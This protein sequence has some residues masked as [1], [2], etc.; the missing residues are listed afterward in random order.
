MKKA[1]EQPEK[2]LAAGE[3]PVERNNFVQHAGALLDVLWCPGDQ[4]YSKNCFRLL[5]R[6][7][8]RLPVRLE[9]AASPI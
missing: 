6:I 8:R 3:F 9:D 4:R 7:W 5:R 1:L 2:A